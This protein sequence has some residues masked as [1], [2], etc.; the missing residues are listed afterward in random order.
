MAWKSQV[1]R[2]R[3]AKAPR[4]TTLVAGSAQAV[5]TLT[6]KPLRAK[7]SGDPPR[8]ALNVSIAEVAA[9]LRIAG[10]WDTLLPRRW[11]SL[12]RRPR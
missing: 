10:R 12:R 8:A 6:D 1:K 2:K 5:K 7:S 11:R 3:G 9:A 4:G